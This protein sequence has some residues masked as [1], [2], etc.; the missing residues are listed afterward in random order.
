[1]AAR[2]VTLTPAAAPI[3][4]SYDIRRYVFDNDIRGGTV[5]LAPALQS[6][7]TLLLAVPDDRR[8]PKHWFLLIVTNPQHKNPKAYVVDSWAAPS[9]DHYYPY[10]QSVRTWLAAV[11]AKQRLRGVSVVQHNQIPA[12]P[13]ASGHSCALHVIWNALRVLAGDHR[14]AADAMLTEVF[15]ELRSSDARQAE[16]QKLVEDTL[17]RFRK[18][19]A[20]ELH[21]TLVEY[22]LAKPPVPTQYANTLDHLN[23]IL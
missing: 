22:N 18:G 7:P 4:V 13:Q 14:L 16:R 9:P 19:F 3:W 23:D 20:K 8:G 1:M 17:A 21:N 5:D 10:L 11:H 6:G 2:N 12:L 15:Y